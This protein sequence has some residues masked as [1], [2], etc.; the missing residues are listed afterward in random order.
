MYILV[1]GQDLHCVLYVQYLYS[2]VV[3]IEP[4]FDG[5]PAPSTK[6]C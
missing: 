5:P 1:A 2:T 4:S 6:R 3:Q